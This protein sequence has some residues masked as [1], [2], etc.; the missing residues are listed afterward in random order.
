MPRRLNCSICIA[1]VGIVWMEK[2]VALLGADLASRV[3]AIACLSGCG[4]LRM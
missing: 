4:F 1:K 3:H 2:I